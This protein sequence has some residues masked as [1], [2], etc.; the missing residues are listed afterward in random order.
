MTI[1]VDIARVCAEIDDLAT[2]SSDPAPAVTRV[3]FTEP[4]MAARSWLIARCEAAG[5]AVRVD[6]VGN[7]FARWQGTH[8]SLP[9]VLTGSHT[10]AVPLAGRFDGV[11][12]VLGG[13]EAIRA[14][15]AAGHRPTRSV[16]L[17]M[18]TSEEPTR[19]GIG[20]VGSRIMAGTLDETRLAGFRDAEGLTLCEV[21]RSVG[22]SG[23]IE[24]ARIDPAGYGAFV[25]LHIEQ[26]PLLEASGTPIGL[27]TA[28]AASAT[29]R[30]KL[31][32]PGGHAGAV[33][34]GERRDPMLAAADAILA[35]DRV[36]RSSDSPDTV[37]TCGYVD[38][39]PG[40]VNSI[41]REVELRIDVRDTD[42]PRRD[43]ILAEIRVDVEVSAARHRVGHTA[44]I[45]NA[46]PPAQ[47]DAAIL[48]A[49]T[50]ACDESRISCVR[51]ISRA[52]HDSA[53]MAR[54]CP[55]AM[56]F[57]PCRDGISHR[58]DEYSSPEDIASGVAVLAGTLAR[59]A[60]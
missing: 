54:V 37:A 2:L 33:L 18:F 28:I 6:G 43:A 22:Y 7:I 26:G 38:V 44:E 30:V 5:L 20:C 24:G 32:G 47:C 11:V 46:D 9:A 21:A 27:V 55:T 16:D 39:E 58:P 57:I 13:L 56:I 10:D 45:L 42:G 36:A 34:M 1:A 53:I 3:I 48:D 19:F 23:D 15:Q 12:G 40:A 41:P 35:A 49:A 31:S 14:L 60:A 17:V 59:L 8:S 52:Y 51:M 50:G 4:D 29:L 25:E